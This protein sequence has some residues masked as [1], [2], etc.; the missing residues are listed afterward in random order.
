M[1]NG[2]VTVCDACM[3]PLDGIQGTHRVKKQYIS[4]K[5]SICLKAFDKNMVGHYVY[6]QTPDYVGRDFMHFCDGTC[7]D[8]YM[9]VKVMLK[10]EYHDK[11]G[12]APVNYVKPEE[13]VSEEPEKPKEPFEPKPNILGNYQ[14]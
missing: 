12:L 4:I 2:I 3:T 14:F 5:G 10:G 8:D 11:N 9:S 1:Q 7:L 13:V 6:A